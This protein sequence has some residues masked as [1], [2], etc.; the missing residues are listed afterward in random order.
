MGGAMPWSNM[1]PNVKHFISHLI[2]KEGIPS[3]F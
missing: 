1:Q 2:E 3:A